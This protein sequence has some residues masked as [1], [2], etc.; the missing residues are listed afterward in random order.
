MTQSSE[1]IK[2]YFKVV[3]ICSKN[4]VEINIRWTLIFLTNYYVCHF[5]VIV[6]DQ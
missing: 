6:N 1:R 3:F 5:Y 4:I 2:S